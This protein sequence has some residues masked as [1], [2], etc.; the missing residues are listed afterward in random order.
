[1]NNKFDSL[2]YLRIC[3]DEIPT[4]FQPLGT[5][6]YESAIGI[7]EIFLY[8]ANL[9][10]TARF[11]ALRDIVSNL[12]IK[13]DFEELDESDIDAVEMSIK[14]VID[15]HYIKLF[16]S[17]II[18]EN[19]EDGVKTSKDVF[20][21]IQMA[22]MVAHNYAEW[23]CS[24]TELRDSGI[25]NRDRVMAMIG[26]CDDVGLAFKTRYRP[27]MG[28]CGDAFTYLDSLSFKNLLSIVNMAALSILKNGVVIRKCRN[29]GDFFIPASRSDE[30]YCNKTLE[31]GKTCKTIGYDERVKGDNILREYRKIYKTQNAR[32][33]R[34]SHIP[35]ISARF[36]SWNVSAKKCLKDC[37]A[38]KL[39]LE[40]L[41]EEISDTQWIFGQ[42]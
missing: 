22:C 39:T 24:P 32:K 9:Y 15:E 35:G 28:Y 12:H 38:G 11:N 2:G 5:S 19:Y 26:A 14:P 29:C 31:S 23:L 17:Y 34:N 40:E 7:K 10:H 37:Q 33:Q 21:M 42:Q 27:I 25:E 8:L 20:C 3:M 1:M 6:F 41:K 16:T 13:E 30:L 36:A 18:A 4:D